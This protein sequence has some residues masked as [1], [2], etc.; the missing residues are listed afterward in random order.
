MLIHPRRGSY[1]FIGVL[2]TDL[3]L[4]ASAPFRETIA[5]VRAHRRLHRALSGAT[6]PA[7]LMDAT[8][9]LDLP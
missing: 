8:L 9:H 1:F 6:T 2:L 3:P 7:P 5:H 4:A